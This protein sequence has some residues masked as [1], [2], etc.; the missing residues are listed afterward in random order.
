MAHFAEFDYVVVNDDFNAA[1]TDLKA[2][3]RAC[4]LR[5]V[6]Q[7]QRQERLIQALVQP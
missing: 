1:L 5:T 7:A 2:V 3:V 6:A 4:R